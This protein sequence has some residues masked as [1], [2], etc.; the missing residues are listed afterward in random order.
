[1]IYWYGEI[2]RWLCICLDGENWLV[3]FF[4]F[5][6]YRLGCFVWGKF[7]FL[8]VFFIMFWFILL[9]IRGLR[10]IVILEVGII[11]RFI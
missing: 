10:I 2:R 6:D 7:L 8:N 5:D 9:V 4:V 3:V 11:L 1:M